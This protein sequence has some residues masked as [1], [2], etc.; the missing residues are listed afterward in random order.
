MHTLI[1]MWMHTHIHT[2]TYMMFASVG[3]ALSHS[4]WGGGWLT[5]S[6]QTAAA[7]I[8]RDVCCA[9][10]PIYNLYVYMKCVNTQVRT[11]YVYI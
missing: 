4:L 1:H 2:N 8:L 5:K 7:G 10:A 3:M 6:W 9:T 11:H